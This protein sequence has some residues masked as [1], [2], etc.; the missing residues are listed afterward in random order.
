MKQYELKDFRMWATTNKAIPMDIIEGSLI[1]N[2]I[3]SCK[4]GIAIV[5]EKFETTWTSKMILIFA[6]KNNI[7][8]QWELWETWDKMKEAAAEYME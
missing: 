2:A 7:P 3:Y 8:D 4:N 1:D 6:R 5:K